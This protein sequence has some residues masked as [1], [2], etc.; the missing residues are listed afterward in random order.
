MNPREIEQI[1]PYPV[2][3]FLAEGGM[4]WV[5]KVEDPKFRVHRALKMLK[6]QAAQ[7]DEFRR[8]ESEAKLLA[9]VE[10]PNLITI[11]DFGHDPATDC[12]YYTMTF[13]DGAPLSETEP[14]PPEA[15]VPIFLDVLSALERLHLQGIIHRDIK[16][17]NILM[18]SDGRVLLGDLGIA[19]QQDQMISLTRTGMAI[20]SVQYMSPEQARGERVT[21]ASD[22]FSMGLALYQVLTGQTI[23]DAVD[24]VDASS[25]EQVLMY[26]GGLIHSGSELSFRF[27]RGV[28]RPLQRV[29]EKACRFDP[30]QRHATAGEL[31]IALLE[32]HHAAPEPRRSAARRPSR[33]A[34]MLLL[35]LLAGLGV[36]VLL[37]GELRGRDARVAEIGP[38]YQAALE[39]LADPKLGV[40]GRRELVATMGADAAPGATA[41]LFV[42]TRDPSAQVA[43]EAVK[44]LNRRVDPEVARHLIGLLDAEEFTV[45]AWAARGLGEAL[46]E[47]A[48]PALEARLAREERPPVAT[49][50]RRAIEQIRTAAAGHEAAA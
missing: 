11:Y 5:F 3:E 19:R 48:L 8:F 10:H 47:P 7:G 25:G 31:R 13:V 49:Q 38:F 29:V 45:R 40:E 36:W 17:G 12:Y 20:G 44:Q 46:W 4:A 43:V 34:A 2:V 23:Y 26:L 28:P 6:P 42:A 15:A 30:A 21:P 24:E 35:G 33:I 9:R 41:V 37:G 14:I 22:V 50:L 39:R 27:P 1:G 32:A 18:M 16:P